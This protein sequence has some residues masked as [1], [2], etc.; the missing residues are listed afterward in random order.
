MSAHITALRTAGGE[1]DH[2][3]LTTPRGALRMR[4][5]AYVLAMGSFSPLL[6]QP[7]G[8]RLP[9]YPA[10]GCSVTM[11]VKDAPGAPR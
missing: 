8:I 11:P 9:I 1:I 2:V 5:D 6:A 7:L 10:K 3:E 4:G